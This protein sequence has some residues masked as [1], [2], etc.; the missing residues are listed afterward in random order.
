MAEPMNEQQAVSKPIFDTSDTNLGS[1]KKGYA[2]SKD[3][4][5]AKEIWN[6]ALEEA[7][8]WLKIED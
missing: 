7:A 6:A 3:S 8:S 4:V 5:Y 1:T 2:V